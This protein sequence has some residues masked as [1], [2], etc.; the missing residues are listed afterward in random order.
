[1]NNPSD[2]HKIKLQWSFQDNEGSSD[3]EFNTSEELKAF[4]DGIKAAMQWI[5]PHIGNTSDKY[6]VKGAEKEPG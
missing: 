3:Y 4:L 6:V 1:M 5:N 2:K